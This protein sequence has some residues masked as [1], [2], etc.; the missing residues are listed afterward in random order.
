MIT[1]LQR[2][3]WPP[4]TIKNRINMVQE[5]PIFP[6]MLFMN[7]IICG[8]LESPGSEWEWIGLLFHTLDPDPNAEMR[9]ELE[10][11]L[12][13]RVR[14]VSALL[15]DKMSKL[16]F[17]EI[18]TQKDSEISWQQRALC[19]LAKTWKWSQVFDILT[20]SGFG[21]IAPRYELWQILPLMQALV[22]SGQAN[23]VWRIV[24]K[25]DF[26]DP[27]MH[28]GEH[29]DEYI[30]LLRS[31]ARKC[32]NFHVQESL[33]FFSPQI[34]YN[35]LGV[36]PTPEAVSEMRKDERETPHRAKKSTVMRVSYNVIRILESLTSEDYKAVC[37]RT[38]TPYALI[39]RMIKNAQ[40]KSQPA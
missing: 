27:S 35:E 19:L 16:S 34:A 3:N 5:S 31:L 22:D 38:E 39:Q 26:F 8:L 24:Q 13:K 33:Q 36:Y 29:S 4:L 15:L 21:D 2:S 7:Q 17:K 18:I 14:V 9:E 28:W 12:E 23:Q 30:L 1:S 25:F 10:N 32:W 40:Q 37:A 6:R 20:H 11:T